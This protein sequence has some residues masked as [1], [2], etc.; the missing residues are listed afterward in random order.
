MASDHVSRR[1]APAFS[2]PLSAGPEESYGFLSTYPPT[3]CGLATFT[4]SLAAAL[5]DGPGAAEIGVVQ[6]VEKAGGSS[7]IEVLHELPTAEPDGEAAAAEVLGRFGVVIVQHEYGIY[8]GRDGE[9]VVQ[10]MRR[11]RA[12]AIVV[13][14]TVLERPTAHQRHVLEDVMGAASAV[15]VMTAT[16]RLRLLGNYLV[17]GAKVEL[18]PHGAPTDWGDSEPR[19]GGSS[20]ILTWGLLGPGKGI[21]WVVSALADLRDLDPLPCYVVAGQTH[22]QVLERDGESYRG[23]L[24]ARAE[25]LGVGHQVRFENRYLDGRSLRELVR[26]A[27]VVVLPYDSTEQVTS[28]VLIEA[29][30]AGRPVV[31]TAFPHAV[32]LLS[33]GAGTIVP[34]RDPAAIAAAVRRVLTEPDVA[35]S[36]VDA[37]R[38]IAPELTWAAVAER[39]RELASRLRSEVASAVA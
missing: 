1:T 15:V 37:A 16:A 27:D 20:S 7:F 12:P 34:H 35:S 26:V 30:T 33:S 24:E 21:E 3:Q 22:P 6:V 25:A 23:M 11:L 19:R 38:R 14:H 29:I 10:V 8:G 32:E 39:Y 17:D 18:I 36:M 31:A 9:S 5:R 4:A 13:L 2:A 28:G